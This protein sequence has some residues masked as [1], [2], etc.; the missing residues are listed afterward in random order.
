M[1]VLVLSLL[2]YSFFPL[3]INI[4]KPTKHLN[5]SRNEFFGLLML[6]T[7]KNYTYKCKQIELTGNNETLTLKR[8]NG[9][10][11]GISSGRQ[12]VACV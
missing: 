12:A 10:V 7:K 4:L 11:Q 3:E 6:C 9:L 2:S 8:I 1:S 5:H